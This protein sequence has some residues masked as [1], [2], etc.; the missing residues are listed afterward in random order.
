MLLNETFNYPTTE[1]EVIER[2][3]M[4]IGIDLE[5]MKNFLISEDKRIRLVPLYKNSL[6]NFFF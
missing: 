5:K 3:S 1:E 4:M 2:L 6:F